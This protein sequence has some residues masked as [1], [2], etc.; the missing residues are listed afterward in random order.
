M[1]FQ[2]IV[3]PPMPAPVVKVPLVLTAEEAARQAEVEAKT[4]GVLSISASVHEGGITVLRW[5]CDGPE[6]VAAV[7]NVD[8]RLLAGLGHVETAEHYYSLILA[9]GEDCA[10]IDTGAG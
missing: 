4:P 3:P 6:R 9:A 8:F 10:G 1:T 5:M 2:R 7:S